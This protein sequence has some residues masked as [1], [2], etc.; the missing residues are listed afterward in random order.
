MSL[1]SIAR[2]VRT[3]L[4]GETEASALSRREFLAG[5][6][7]AGGLAIASRMLVD[8]AR[9]E[10]ETAELPADEDGDV[11]L[12]QLY[13]PDRGRRRRRFDDDWDYHDRGRF[14]R[15]ARRREVAYWCRHDRVFRRRNRRL[16]RR[17]LGRRRWRRGTCI[18]IGP[19]TICE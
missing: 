7:A 18:Q 2:A 13:E 9:A 17:V 3:L 5:L 6:G 16:C 12:T 19:L 8:Q 11:E 15:R 14:H 4:T 1:T 10:P